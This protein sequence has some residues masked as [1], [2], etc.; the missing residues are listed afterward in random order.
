MASWWR[1]MA[2]LGRHGGDRQDLRAAG[3]IELAGRPRRDHGPQ[4]LA[5]AG[6]SLL[7]A[8]NPN[9]S[10]TNRAPISIRSPAVIRPASTDRQA[11]AS[12][13]R[14]HPGAGSARWVRG[15]PYLIPTLWLALNR[16]NER[17]PTLARPQTIPPGQKRLASEPRY[18]RTAHLSAP[19]H[20]AHRR[21][22]AGILIVRGG[23]LVTPRASSAGELMDALKAWERTGSSHHASAKVA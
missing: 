7:F 8:G 13:A 22:S 2:G 10:V 14:H 18:V 5:V 17:A 23:I 20:S 19:A 21:Q 9:F 12:P 1:P 16:A 4:S 3:A 6:R 11:I 15:T